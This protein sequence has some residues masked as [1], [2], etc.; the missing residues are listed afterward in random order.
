MIPFISTD[1]AETL[2]EKLTRDSRRGIYP[3]A[4]AA[5]EPLLRDV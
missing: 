2:D 1:R 3:R 4:L 5:A